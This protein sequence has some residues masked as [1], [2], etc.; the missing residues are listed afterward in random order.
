MTVGQKIAAAPNR[1]KNI[2]KAN[3]GK[4]PAAHTVEAT[5]AVRLGKTYEEIHGYERAQE[6]KEKQ[7]L[8]RKHPVWTEEMRRLAGERSKKHMMGRKATD[9]TKMK[10]STSQKKRYDMKKNKGTL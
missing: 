5:I 1:K 6:I 9:E 7:K 10:M 2:S 8:N 3:K 4:K